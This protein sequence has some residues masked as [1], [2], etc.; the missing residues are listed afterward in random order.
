LPAGFTVRVIA[1][2]L[3]KLPEVPVT[4]TVKVPMDAV[5]VAERVRRLVVVAGF[6]LNTALT[7]LGKP[8]AVKFTLPLKPFRGLIV[9]VAKPEP[10]WRMVKV[11]GYAE[12][13]KPA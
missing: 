12:R 11:V 7:P 9:M 5:P 2:L 3:V 4:A 8:D 6:V 1:T 10:P 13:V